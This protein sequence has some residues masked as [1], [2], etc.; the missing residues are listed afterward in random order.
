[1]S[2][3]VIARRPGRDG[4]VCSAGRGAAVGIHHC[5]DRP[6]RPLVRIRWGHN[7]PDWALPPRARAQPKH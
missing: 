7:V 6:R 5:G 3:V 1:M 4:L 2:W